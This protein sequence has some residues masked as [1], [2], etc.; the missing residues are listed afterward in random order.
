MLV[1][2]SYFGWI[3]TA[4]VFAANGL[5]DGSLRVSSR[6]ASLE[7][8]K[9]IGERVFGAMMAAFCIG[10]V[11]LLF[12]MNTDVSIQRHQTPHALT[13]LDYFLGFCLFCLTGSLGIVMLYLAGPNDLFLDKDR[14]NYRFVSGWPICSQIQTGA[15]EDIAGI[16]VKRVS[17]SRSGISYL[18][19]IAW[20]QERRNFPL[21]GRFRREEDAE[22]MAEE[23]SANLELPRVLPPP[24]GKT[25]VDPVAQRLPIL[26]VTHPYRPFQSTLFS[27]D[28]TAEPKLNKE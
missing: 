28:V 2:I 8:R 10:T 5:R 25:A 24:P 7:F 6:Q 4:L 9:R 18:V 22:A 1:G 20:R 21:L 13:S 27:E 14:H 15:W 12:W 16:Y 17:G 3:I 11:P 26:L 23:L 19:A